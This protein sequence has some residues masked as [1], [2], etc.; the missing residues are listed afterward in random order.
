[1]RDEHRYGL[2]TRQS[3]KVAESKPKTYKV[4]D[5]ILRRLLMLELIDNGQVEDLNAAHKIVSPLSEAVMLAWLEQL[6]RKIG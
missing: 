4:Q 6:G 3:A 2:P 5:A 1:M